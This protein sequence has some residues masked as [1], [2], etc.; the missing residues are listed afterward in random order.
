MIIRQVDTLGDWAFGRGRSSYVTRGAAVA[1]N[2]ATR[3]RSFTGDCF[4]DAEAGVDWWNLLGAKDQTALNLAIAAAILNTKD[5]T[6]LQRVSVL[7]DPVTR[8]L[9]VAWQVETSFS[10]VVSGQFNFQVG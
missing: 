8:N 3:L 10:S 2:I 9:S 6:K 5:V 7:V 1:Q 4:F